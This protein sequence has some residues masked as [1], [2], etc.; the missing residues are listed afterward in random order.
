MKF[1]ARVFWLKTAAA[2]SLKTAAAL[3]AKLANLLL[4]SGL[5]G[6]AQAATLTVVVSNVPSD[7]GKMNFAVYD[8]KDA[9]LEDDTMVAKQTLV[10]PST[11]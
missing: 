10:V 11:R 2:P 8:S 9:W 6:L 1:S 3:S 5:A 4:L 7:S